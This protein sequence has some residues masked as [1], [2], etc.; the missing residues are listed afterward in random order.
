MVHGMSLVATCSTAAA[1]ACCMLLTAV[2]CIAPV[3]VHG[4]GATATPFL[5]LAH[6]MAP[7]RGAAKALF[8]L[9]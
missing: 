3:A 5:G 7:A 4:M 2:D 8:S 9:L 6:G 1:A